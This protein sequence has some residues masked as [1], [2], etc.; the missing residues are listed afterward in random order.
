VSETKL[1]TGLVAGILALAQ[2][3]ADQ[4][5]VRDPTVPPFAPAAAAL[6]DTST[7]PALRLHSTRVSASA[8]SAVINGRIVTPGSRVAGATVLSI[9]SGRVMLQRGTERITLRIAAPTVK[10]LAQGDES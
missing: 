2:A 8:Q 6:E 1:A 9:E 3:A 10:K 7:G 4:P 5:P